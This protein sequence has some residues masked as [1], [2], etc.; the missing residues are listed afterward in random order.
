M[1]AAAAPSLRP[2]TASSSFY[3]CRIVVYKLP[4]VAS[5]STCNWTTFRDLLRKHFTDWELLIIHPNTTILLNRAGP[6][7]VK[8]LSGNLIIL[9]CYVLSLRQISKIRFENFIAAIV[10]LISA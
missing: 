5:L 8:L 1:A 4:L 9:C 6:D 10:T 2:R 3:F 7:S